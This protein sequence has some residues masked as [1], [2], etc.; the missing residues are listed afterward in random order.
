MI[1]GQTLIT[2]GNVQSGVHSFLLS[3]QSQQILQPLSLLKFT[4]YCA[5]LDVYNLVLSDFQHY[6]PPGHRY[7]YL[8][9][10]S[11]VWLS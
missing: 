6:W 3:W 1:C 8:G 11:P 7:M 10:V 9:G 2:A 5:R 4:I